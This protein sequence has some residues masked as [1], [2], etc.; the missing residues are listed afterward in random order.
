MHT[1]AGTNPRRLAATSRV[2]PSFSPPSGAEIKEE[3]SEMERERERNRRR[4][5]FVY[6]A[7]SSSS[8]STAVFREEVIPGEAVACQQPPDAAVPGSV[9]RCSGRCSKR[10]R[11]AR[12]LQARGIAARFQLRLPPTA[13]A[14]TG[15]I[16]PPSS[17][18]QSL[19]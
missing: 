16:T 17:F 10:T 1:H 7:L 4:S 19:Q 15:T 13:H 3:M 2:S 5:G 12:S 9:L 18:I 6:R 14:R 11:P 8:S